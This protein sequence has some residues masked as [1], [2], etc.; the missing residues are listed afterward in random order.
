[1]SETSNVVSRQ[2]SKTGIE[3]VFFVQFTKEAVVPLIH[4]PRNSLSIIKYN[5]VTW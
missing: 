1:M 4:T 5:S 2:K 3:G